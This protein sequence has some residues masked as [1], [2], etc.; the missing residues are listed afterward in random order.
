VGLAAQKHLL[1]A[2]FTADAR[3]THNSLEL[4]SD[5][6]GLL[7]DVQLILLGF[8]VQSAVFDNSD[9]DVAVHGSALCARPSELN[10]EMTQ[11]EGG[12]F[13]GGGLPDR[14]VAE[15]VRFRHRPQRRH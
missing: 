6:R 9:E 10:S 3:L 5:S 1:R 12:A 7:E 4:A 11:C 15:R 8:G 13:A 2:M 14:H